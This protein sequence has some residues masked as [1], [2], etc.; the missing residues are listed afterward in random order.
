M[1]TEADCTFNPPTPYLLA[2]DEDLDV[3]F[4]CDEAVL[5][6]APLGIDVG[7]VLKVEVRVNIFA[8]HNQFKSSFTQAI[9]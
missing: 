7:D 1:L 2:G 3:T 9:E 8:G 5:V 4:S 6:L